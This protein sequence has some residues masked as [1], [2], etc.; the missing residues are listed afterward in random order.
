LHNPLEKACYSDADVQA[1]A[2]D[3]LS[4]LRAGVRAD[5]NV[6]VDT[7]NEY[8]ELSCGDLLDTPIPDR[9]I[10]DPSMNLHITPTGESG[11]TGYRW[12]N[13][14]LTV[15]LLKVAGDGSADFTLQA[16]DDQP[17]KG[18]GNKMQR[19]GGTYAQ[20]FTIMGVGPANKIPVFV[21][22][23][24]ENE[25]GLLYEAALFWHYS[26]L[27]DNIQRGEAASIPC[28]GAASYDSALTQE[29][30]GLTLGQYVEWRDA[31]EGT[32][33]LARFASLLRTISNPPS[34]D[35][36]NQALLD[37]ADL[38]ANNDMLAEYAKYRDYVPGSVIPEQQLLDI[39]KNLTDGGNTN[40]STVDGVPNNVINIENIDHESLGPNAVL[41]RRNWIDLRQ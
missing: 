28:Y 31:L 30:R 14:A 33:D 21:D 18:T 15:Q 16:Q 35:L 10:K 17:H 12:R 20:G 13:G 34:E 19:I 25:S 41:G 4:G 9:Y 1:A 6:L 40:T 23:S 39:D 38:L 26:D 37:L 11:Y 29:E 8:P 36:L 5:T 24:T 7:E 27:A 22:A 3:I 2:D 32:E